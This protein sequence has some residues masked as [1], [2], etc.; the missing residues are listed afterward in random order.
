MFDSND[1]WGVS[2]QCKYGYGTAYINQ[3]LVGDKWRVSCNRVWSA[4]WCGIQQW[5]RSGYGGAINNGW[6]CCT[7]HGAMGSGVLRRRWLAAAEANM[8]NM[9]NVMLQ[10]ASTATAQQCNSS[11]HGGV[12][13]GSNGARS[14]AITPRQQQLAM[15]YVR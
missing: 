5:R 7:A 13:D 2:M 12:R 6:L 1:G 9:C 11:A 8:L 4:G 14:S 10:Y 15:Q 3:R